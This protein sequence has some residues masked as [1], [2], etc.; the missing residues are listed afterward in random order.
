MYPKVKPCTHFQALSIRLEKPGPPE[1]EP[2]EASA[3][4]PRV[5]VRG[6][7][8]SSRGLLPAGLGLL[9]CGEDNGWP[10]PHS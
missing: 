3:C 8:A 4:L 6:S 9:R 1:P 5:G 2:V 10:N 7:P